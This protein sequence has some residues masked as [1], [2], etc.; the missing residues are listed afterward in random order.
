MSNAIEIRL[1]G[2][3]EVRWQ[4]QPL[5]SKLPHKAFALLSYLALAEQPVGREMLAMLL[6]PAAPLPTAKQSLRNLLSQLRPV[7]GDLLEIAQRTVALA[8]PYRQR[9]DVVVFQQGLAAIQQAQQ[10]GQS[11]DLALWQATLDLYRGEFL[12]GFYIHQSE[13]FE[14]WTTLCRESLRQQLLTNLLALSAAYAA[15]DA[16]EA[17][18]ACLDRL[19]IVE[20]EHEAAYSQQIQLLMRL[21]RRT[22]ARQRYERY[23]K[24]LADAFNLPPSPALTALLTEPHTQ[25]GSP[26]TVTQRRVDI[27]MGP[28]IITTE[29]RRTAGLP[30]SAPSPTAPP[31]IPNNLIRPLSVFVGRAHEVAY[32]YQR[33]TDADCRLVTIVGPGGMGKS[34]LALA[35]GQ[36]LLGAQAADF[37]DGI[38]WVPLAEISGVEPESNAAEPANDA[39]ASEAILRAIATQLGGELAGGIASAGQLETYLRPRRLL[40]IVDNFEHLAAGTAALVTLLTKAPQLKL[41]ITSRARLNVRGETVLPLDQLSL[42]TAAYHAAIKAAQ[43]NPAH[44]IPTEV[45]QTSEAV[46]MFV[47]R[48]QQF[49]PTFTINAATI[50]PVGQICQLV[51]G[52]PLGIELATSMLPLLSCSALAKDLAKSLDFLAADTRDLPYE[53][54][55]LRS[56]FERSWQLLSPAAQLLLARLSI[57]PGSF[58]REAAEY[59]VGASLGPLQH[60]L[61]QSLL[62][63]T[64]AERY[65]LHRTIH[66]FA[67]QKLQRWPEYIETL[68]VQYVHFYLAFLARQERELTGAGYAVAIEQIQADLDNVQTAWRRAITYSMVT[69]LNRCVEALFLF[70]EQHRFYLGVINLYEEAMHHFSSQQ[71]QQNHQSSAEITLLLGRLQAYWGSRLAR[72]GRFQQAQAA[73]DASWSTL[74]LVDRPAATAACLGFMGELLKRNNP[75]RAAALLTEAVRLIEKTDKGWIK[76]LIYQV[77]G[78]INFLFGNYAEADAQIT[79]GRALAKQMAWARGLASAHKSLGRISLSLGHYRQAEAYLREG[80]SVARQHHLNILCLESTIGLGE[81]LRL[82]GHVD[83]AHACFVESR[84]L[85]EALDGGLLMAP[86][87]WEEGCLAEQRGEYKV[88]KA[89]FAE[90]LAIGLPPWWSHVLPT[91]G[92]ALLGL[93]EVEEAQIYFQK[94]LAAAEA[95]ERRPIGLDAQVGLAYIQYLRIRQEGQQG[96]VWSAKGVEL[97]QAIYEQP[98]TTAETRQRIGKITAELNLWSSEALVPPQS[99]ITE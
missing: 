74:Q 7:L 88:A 48:A 64:G 24:M 5:D 61:D 53:Q 49:D 25:A 57:F 8:A 3:P 69:E 58:R 87:L 16:N 17:A 46:A 67:Q 6:W 40:L 84:Q 32:L 27:A 62:S 12:A 51:E 77:L 76:V 81:A 55:T 38:F 97:L 23:C 85:V 91:L 11:L 45:W 35:L 19:L 31:T 83:D 93:G 26:V 99:M 90:S 43:A 2:H 14:E 20:P 22:E 34:S 95:E 4:G 18:L 66:A 33:L 59:I 1:F 10:S 47:Q 80:I 96:Q 52:L 82:Q 28:S 9:A 42:P 73:Y 79:R 56:V 78:E 13:P 68:Q 92:W 89:R 86:V 30:P 65:V 39:S 29:L 72:L 60:L 44:A 70:S 37:P 98:A 21:G 75:K 36:R 54:R 63:K 50:G 71:A 41:L 15:R 94:A